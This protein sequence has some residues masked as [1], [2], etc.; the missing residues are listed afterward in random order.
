MAAMTQPPECHRTIARQTPR[1]VLPPRRSRRAPKLTRSCQ[2]SFGEPPRPKF[3]LF[4]PSGALFWPIIANF[5][6]EVQQVETIWTRFA[7]VG[8]SLA[9]SG[10]RLLTPDQFRPN[11]ADVGK[12]QP[13]STKV[14]RVWH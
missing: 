11:T 5:G 7:N 14:D 10:D 8:Q 3:G 12:N 2:K 4:R 9:E 6:P 1:K 13:S